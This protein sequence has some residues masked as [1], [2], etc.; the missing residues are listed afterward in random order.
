MMLATSCKHLLRCIYGS[1]LKAAFALLGEALWNKIT[2]PWRYADWLLH[3][4]Q[5]ENEEIADEMKEIEDE[6]RNG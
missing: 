1:N 4:K 2:Y 5:W 6:V 3:R